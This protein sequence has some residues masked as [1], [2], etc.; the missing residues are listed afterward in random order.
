MRSLYSTSTD[1]S[2]NINNNNN[3]DKK[4]MAR[5]L[6]TTDHLVVGLNP[7][8]LQKATHEAGDDTFWA[9]DPRFKGMLHAMRVGGKSGGGEEDRQAIL[10][11]IRAGS[12]SPAE[13]VAAMRVHS[14]A[15]LSRILMLNPDGFRGEGKVKWS[16]AS[17]G[18]DSMVGAAL[19]NWIFRELGLDITFQ[20]PL[21]PLLTITGLAELVYANPLRCK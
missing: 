8:R 7:S 13:A 14:V 12:I 17:Y 6:P 10:S 11:V 9:P 18:V 5:L 15:E 21:G 3:N 16:V 2:I 19:R 1:T 4:M 20:P